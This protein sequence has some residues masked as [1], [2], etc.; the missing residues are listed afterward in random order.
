MIIRTNWLFSDSS[1]SRCASSGV[2][3]WAYRGV[4]VASG[5]QGRASLLDALFC[6][7]LGL[8]VRS[9]QS[10][11]I[12]IVSSPQE[13]TVLPVTRDESCLLEPLHNPDIESPRYC[14][15][16]FFQPFQAFGHKHSG[17]VSGLGYFLFRYFL[18]LQSAV[19]TSFTFSVR[20]FFFPTTDD[21]S[22]SQYFLKSPS[23][24]S[25]F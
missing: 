25:S 8:F 6:L 4:G 20:I 5:L 19:L 12:V 24:C 23:S 11:I 14:E 2:S 1:L 18:E 7:E 22:L 16:L 15:S 13:C 3:G 21:R 10:P 9:E 17:R